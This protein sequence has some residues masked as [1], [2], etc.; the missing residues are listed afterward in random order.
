FEKGAI[1]SAGDDIVSKAYIDCLN[2]MASFNPVLESIG[3]NADHLADPAHV[4][5][6]IEF[7][8]EG[9][10][11]SKMLNKDAVGDAGVYRART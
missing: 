11:L 1:V 9:L 6:G 10:H 5:S 2:Q 8:L 7:I 4:A 3:L